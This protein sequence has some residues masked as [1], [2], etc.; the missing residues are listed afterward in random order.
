MYDHLKT[1]YPKIHQGCTK[2]YCQ[3]LRLNKATLNDYKYW[4]DSK[5]I[6][7]EIPEG[8]KQIGILDME[9]YLVG[10][11]AFMIIETTPDF[12][13]DEAFERLAKL[14][15]QAEWEEF[16][17]RFQVVDQ[18][19]R[20]DEKWQLAERIFSLEKSLSEQITD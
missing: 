19:K 16:V 20:S 3:Y 18:G 2:R 17:S 11:H 8:I 9:I 13:W 10:I 5:H 12:M 15:R 4:H 14:D 6:W 1:G 7:K